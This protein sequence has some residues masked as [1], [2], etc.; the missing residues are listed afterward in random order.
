MEAPKDA[1]PVRLSNWGAVGADDFHE[2]LEAF[3]TC[4]HVH[5]VAPDLDDQLLGEHY[6][7]PQPRPERVPPQV[8]VPVESH[9]RDALVELRHLPHGVQCHAPR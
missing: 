7:R 1:N 6:P 8:V 4:H 2:I 9:P 3:A 5:N